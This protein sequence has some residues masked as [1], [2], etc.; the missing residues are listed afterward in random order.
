[1]TTETAPR[2]QIRIAYA[3]TCLTTEKEKATRWALLD[4][5]NVVKT[6]LVYTSKHLAKR[7]PSIGEIITLDASDKAGT[8]IYSESAR[9]AGTLPRDHTERMTWDADATAAEVEEELGRRRKKEIDAASLNASLAHAK[10]MYGRL[11]GNRR[12][13]AFL[14]QVI[15]YVTG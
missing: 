7:K 3:G 14:A 12:R 9:Y 6:Y 1:M 10:A 13:A 4:E 5:N 2:V 8:S 11:I 15:Q